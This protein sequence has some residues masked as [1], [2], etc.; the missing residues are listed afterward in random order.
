MYR[1]E[2]HSV[3]R[4]WMRE[5]LARGAKAPVIMEALFMQREARAGRG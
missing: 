1:T 2:P 3:W 4:A 5:N